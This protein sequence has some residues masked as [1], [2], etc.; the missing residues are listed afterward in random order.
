MFSKF[1]MAAIFAV[2]SIIAIWLDGSYI[3]FGILVTVS[4]FIYFQYL[5]GKVRFPKDSGS[6]PDEADDPENRS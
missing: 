6:L 5:Q 1:T 2:L 4:L 3:L